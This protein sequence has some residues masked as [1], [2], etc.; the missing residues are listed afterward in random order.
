MTTDAYGADK[1][2]K[3]FLRRSIE[4]ALSGAKSAL[5]LTPEAKAKKDENKQV[6]TWTKELEL[7][8]KFVSD[9]QDDAVKCVQ[10]YL[11]DPNT[12]SIAVGSRYRLN[13]FH[14]NITTLTSIMYAKLPK[15]EADRRFADPGDDVG[16]VASEMVT[17]I[18]Q[19]DMNDPE[20][21]LNNVLKQALQDR[22]V[23]G[24][25]AGRIR[26]CMEEKD[27]PAYVAP[28][29]AP[30]DEPVP[31]VKKDEWC[32]VEYVHWRDMLWS[33][34][35]TPA[36]LRWVAFRAYMT[37]AECI[38]RFGEDVARDVPY[39]SRG[40]KLDPGEGT[41][42][43]ISQFQDRAQAEVWEI[44]DKMAK[45][46]YWYVKGYDQ[47]LD[48]Q[49]DPMEL[50]GFF[51]NAPLMVANASTLKYLPKPD[52]LMAR[53]LYE[54]INEL[55]VRIAM[56][57]KACKLVGVYPAAAKEIQR[58]LTEAVENQLIAV[59]AWAMFADKG[60]L[61]GQIEYL[62]IK[63]VAETLQ[64]LVI[65][66]QQRIQQ[67][68]QVTGMSD[69]IRGQASQGGVT[70]TEQRIKAQFASTRMQSFQDEFANFASE[71]LNRK[72]Q[73]IR[74]YYDPERIKR[75]SNIM[76]TPD[77]PLADKA[78]ALIKDEENFDCRVAVKSDSMAQIDFEAL[79]TERSEFM[80]GVASFLGST[81]PVLKEMPAAAPFLMELLKFNLAGMKGAQ[82][83]EG[84][85]DQ[86]I[87][88]LGKAEQEKAAKP[89][90]PTPEE[91]AAKIK[92]DGAIQVA[93]AKA[94][95]D[96]QADAQT[97]QSDMA[98]AQQEHALEIQKMEQEMA[99]DREEH[100]LKVQEMEMKLQ[101]LQAQLGF[102]VQESQIK[103][104]GEQ[105]SQALE[106]AG[107]EREFEHDERRMDME[108]DHAEA[109]FERESEQSEAQFE[110]QT[111][112]Q[113]AAARREARS[114]GG[115]GSE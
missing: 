115:E 4:G 62:P 93:Q 41:Q 31:Q 19:N 6:Q 79:K 103:L 46:V 109:S 15:V 8:E 97:A 40:P 54:E 78:I 14:S 75:L 105:Q 91:K 9:W 39:A 81:G 59:E 56:L 102:K 112:H 80:N 18:L 34:C 22:L 47:F 90:E 77:A 57:T 84:V 89:P 17:R 76:N 42:A 13:L 92:T 63:E 44:W 11:D 65:Q 96:A 16:R 100:Q 12:S 107:Q 48:C 43:D 74:K 32:D 101:L 35:R 50:G 51:P 25:G 27:D 23:V 52:Y 5:G 30:E 64:I 45:K 67:L 114:P 110:Q 2:D 70:A 1:A 82:A 20:D 85:I 87:A 36:E 86:G 108:E 28:E 26:Y 24:L 29:G 111:R 72:V 113:E 71:L 33:P 55:E 73:L 66:Q 37:K 98:I 69:I 38:A 68:Y 3:G 83:M 94:S 58:I 60:G 21:R 106:A 104:Q 7:A 53:D 99:M 61:K 88:A 95:A 49:D 10:A